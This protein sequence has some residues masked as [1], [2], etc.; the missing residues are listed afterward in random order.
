MQKYRFRVHDPNTGYDLLT[1][2]SNDT[3]ILLDTVK[4]G[5]PTSLEDREEIQIIITKEKECHNG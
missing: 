1:S 3:D 2:Q 4:P 5:L